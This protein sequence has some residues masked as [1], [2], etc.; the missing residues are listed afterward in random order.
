MGKAR[1][2]ARML[3]TDQLQEV[4]KKATSLTFVLPFFWRVSGGRGGSKDGDL[5]TGRGSGMRQHGMRK[6]NRSSANNKETSQSH[7]HSKQSNASKVMRVPH[8]IAV[9]GHICSIY[10]SMRTHISA[11]SA[12]F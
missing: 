12:R 8:R 7:R 3:K 4:K 10:S 1:E 11:L 2:V 5:E 6:G 9:C